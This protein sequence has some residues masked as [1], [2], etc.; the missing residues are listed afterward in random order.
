MPCPSVQSLSRRSLSF[1]GQPRFL[2][3]D[4]KPVKCLRCCSSV[5]FY[6]TKP[7]QS[8]SRSALAKWPRSHCHVTRHEFHRKYHYTKFAQCLFNHQARNSRLYMRVV[9]S[10]SCNSPLQLRF[11][12]CP[13]Q[14]CL[15]TYLR[16]QVSLQ[17]VPSRGMNELSLAV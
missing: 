13:F 6:V 5:V 3:F 17:V 9:S 2:C 11:S 14:R 15:L 1:C 10:M 12:F 7:M 8:L 16:R 4:R